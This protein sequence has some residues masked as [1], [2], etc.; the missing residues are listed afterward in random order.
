VTVTADGDEFIGALEDLDGRRLF[1]IYGPSTRSIPE[2]AIAI[3]TIVLFEDAVP[4]DDIE[5]VVIDATGW[6]IVVNGVE[7]EA[8]EAFMADDG[9][10]V[11]VPLRAIAEALEFEVTWVPGVRAVELS[12]MSGVAQVWARIVIGSTEAVQ[13][14]ARRGEITIGLPAAPVIIGGYTFVPLTTF[15]QDVLEMANA[16]AFEGRLEVLSEGERME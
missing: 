8:P 11:M 12:G 3:E 4:L 2:L 15:F 14:Y 9:V 13:T 1:V 10:T 7:I 5:D 6:P 16:F